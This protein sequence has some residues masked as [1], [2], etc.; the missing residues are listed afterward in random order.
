MRRAVRSDEKDAILREAYWSGRRPLCQRCYDK[1][2]LENQIQYAKECDLCQRMG[3]PTEQARMPHQ[4]FLPLDPSKKWGLDFVRPFKLPAMRTYNRYIIVATDYCTKWVEAIA[5]RD[6]IAS[7]TTKFLYEY[8][9]WKLINTM[10]I[11][12][13]VGDFLTQVVESLTTFYAVVH[14]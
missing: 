11:S 9:W 10:Q 4:P 6:D 3:Q 5:L 8:I 2:K 1:E 12:D 14:K 13:Q 7:S